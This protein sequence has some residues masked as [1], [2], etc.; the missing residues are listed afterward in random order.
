MKQQQKCQTRNVER[1]THLGS[2]E[3]EDKGQN[4]N[5]LP[6]PPPPSPAQVFGIPQW[7]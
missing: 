6:H 3:E 4:M 7:T 2:L 5:N 1:E